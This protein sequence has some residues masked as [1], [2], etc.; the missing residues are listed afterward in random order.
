[1]HPARAL[2]DP[3]ANYEEK[4]KENKEFQWVLLGRILILEPFLDYLATLGTEHSASTKKILWTLFQ[5]QYPGFCLPNDILKYMLIKAFGEEVDPSDFLKRAHKRVTSMLKQR[6]PDEAEDLRLFCVIDEAQAL[7]SPRVPSFSPVLREILQSFSAADMTMIIV[8][9]SLDLQSVQRGVRDTGRDVKIISDLG[10]F[11]DPEEQLGY[12]VEVMPDDYKN[13]ESAKA[14]ETRY[15]NWCRGRYRYTSTCLGVH[16]MNKFKSPHTIFN[17][18]ITS[19]TGIRPSDFREYKKFSSQ[20]P[21]VEEERKSLG[22]NEA[23]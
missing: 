6:F 12:L 7:F 5:V 14:L 8:G 23:I 13:T 11:D 2:R 9:T 3:T 10:G 20:E 1:M 22:S 16:A 21:V 18:Y 19:L 4:K 15:W 17:Q